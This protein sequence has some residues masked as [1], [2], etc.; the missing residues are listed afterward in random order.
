M[1]DRSL[2]AL[3][4]AAIREA[5][6]RSWTK[7]PV[8]RRAAEAFVEQGATRVLDVGAGCGK[9]CIA[10]AMSCRSL[11]LVGWERDPHLVEIATSVAATLGVPNARFVAGDASRVSWGEFEGI[12][13][14][15]PFDDEELE[16]IQRIERSLEEARLGMVVVTFNRFGGRVPIGW[17]LAREERVDWTWLRTWVKRRPAKIAE[18]YHLEQ[19]TGA[20]RVLTSG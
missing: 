19:P 12:Y 4:P 2:D 3:Y 14:F 8:A 15:R 1:D 18:G 17:E 13:L 7:V 9:F 16:E 20:V 6:E 10:A 5:A 11:E